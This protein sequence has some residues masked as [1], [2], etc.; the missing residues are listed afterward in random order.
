ME[1]VSLPESVTTITGYAFYGCDKLSNVYYSGNK[2]KWNKIN[3]NYGND[4]L[5]NATVTYGKAPTYTIISTTKFGTI[6][7]D[8]TSA[9]MG[10]KITFTVTPTS[11]YMLTDGSVKVNNGEVSVTSNGSSYSFTMP[12]NN[13]TITAT[14]EKIPPE[15]V[16]VTFNAGDGTLKGSSTMKVEKG[17]ALTQSGIPTAEKDG[18]KFSGWLLNGKTFSLDTP[19][20][21]NIT[22]TA[23]WLENGIQKSTV[24]TLSKYA[25]IMN[26]EKSAG[27]NDGAIFTVTKKG[28]A[29]VPQPVV[30]VAHFGTDGTLQSADKFDFT[31]NGDTYTAIVDKQTGNYK[32][33]VW[34]DDAASMLEP[35]TAP[36]TAADRVFE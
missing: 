17:K 36:L 31:K 26:F 4:N 21:E 34:T 12:D 30:F 3:F 5:K 2:N 7:P 23:L 20:T 35:I 32:L 24:P 13:V 9:A 19:I 28:N 33:F 15:M 11:G 29:K 1:A 16:T 14:F 27:A 8:K 10:E 22:L 18:Y 25:D 6:T